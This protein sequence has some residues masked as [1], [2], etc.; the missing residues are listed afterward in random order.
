MFMQRWAIESANVYLKYLKEKQLGI[1]DISVN[2]IQQ[3]IKNPELFFMSIVKPLVS[4]SIQIRINTHICTH[5]EIRPVKYDKKT[6][7][8]IVRALNEF[9]EI[10]KTA[11][12]KTVFVSSDL[13]FLVERVHNWYLQFGELLAIPKDKPDVRYIARDNETDLSYDQT[14]AVQGILSNPLTYVWGAPGTGKTKVVLAEV[15]LSYIMAGK[16]VLL[17][18]PTNNALEQTLNGLL[19]VMSNAGFDCDELV[20]RLGI[21]SSDFAEKYPGVCENTAEA[22][23]L[24]ELNDRITAL[25]NQIEKTEA[26]LRLFPKY[27][28]FLDRQRFIQ[29]Y[30]DAAP[31]LLI[32]VFGYYDKQKYCRD[33]IAK[34]EG[35]VT[36]DSASLDRIKEE[37]HQ[38]TE[39]IRELTEALKKYDTPFKKK[40][41]AKKFAL[42][43]E[44]LSSLI[45]KE[46]MAHQ[47]LLSVEERIKKS[48][49]EIDSYR[50]EIETATEAIAKN[51]EA[52]LYF[53]KFD[54]GLT[55][56]VHTFAARLDKPSS[57]GLNAHFMAI[58]EQADNEESLYEEIKGKS[59]SELKDLC[60]KLKK[61]LA[62]CISFKASFEENSKTSKRY[63]KCLVVAATTDTCLNRLLPNEDHGFSHVFL[64]EAGYCSLIKGCTLFAFHTPV[65]FLGDHMQLPPICEMNEAKI[66]ENGNRPV[67]L[68]AQSALYA[69]TVFVEDIAKAYDIYINRREY[70]YRYTKKYN[71]NISYRFGPALASVLR[72][73]VYS[74]DFY[75][76]ATHETEL[77][78]IDVPRPRNAEEHTSLAEVKAIEQYINT[79]ENENIGVITPYRAQL[80]KMNNELRKYRWM[81][82]SILTVHRSQGREWDT[83][84]F[85]AAETTKHFFI[86]SMNRASD[87]KKLVNTAVSRARKKLIIVCDYEYW[88]T[89]KGQLICKILEH[90]KPYQ[91][92]T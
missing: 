87:G 13:T 59:E 9:V 10:L 21:P 57:R 44:E 8:L 7:T 22:Q 54:T 85:S 83:V 4:D 55:A 33:E 6:K 1:S 92:L 24:S 35:R 43:T 78:Y 38:H 73:D 79:H 53:A 2:G 64:D 56:R 19:P 14:A 45:E 76:A 80:A 88:I 69:E 39:K 26:L 32:T 27:Y 48:Q 50:E 18:A 81:A 89:Q 65:T 29:E 77:L 84:L 37:E 52:L 42:I 46:E 34:L 25:K 75:G 74:E 71:L 17:T 72:A 58:R 5:N 63:E 3:D 91:E 36:L 68:W 51:I 41:H 30:A 31:S 23:K 28:A 12:T 49:S 20:I 15:I 40:I 70:D 90:A 86:D 47:S 66:K 61:N 60:E 62:D 11:E 16:K 82:D 67:F